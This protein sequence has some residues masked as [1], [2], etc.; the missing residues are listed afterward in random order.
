MPL[1]RWDGETE[2]DEI[3]AWDCEVDTWTA[4]VAQDW[5]Q[6]AER[7]AAGEALP[8]QAAQPLPS[9]PC[10]RH[11]QPP[12]SA[13]VRVFGPRCGELRWRWSSS[14][15]SAHCGVLALAA[16]H[17]VPSNAWRADELITAVGDYRG[18]RR[19]RCCAS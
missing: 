15:G 2:H 4:L 6:A 13:T 16:N 10:R 5:Q 14:P 8:R 7:A 3:G 1:G 19:L 18:C 9:W 17:L 12:T 11:E